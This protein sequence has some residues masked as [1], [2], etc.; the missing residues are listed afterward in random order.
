MLGSRHAGA[1]AP[2][3]RVKLTG[4]SLLKESDVSALAGTDVRPLLLRRWAG[5]PQLTRDPLGSSLVG[6]TVPRAT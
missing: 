3:E 2:N 6:A 4:L 5:R 1:M